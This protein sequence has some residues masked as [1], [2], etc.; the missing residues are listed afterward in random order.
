MSNIL[1]IGMILLLIVFVYVFVQAKR[2]SEKWTE[3]NN[4]AVGVTK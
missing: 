4:N 2:I 3:T 1:Y